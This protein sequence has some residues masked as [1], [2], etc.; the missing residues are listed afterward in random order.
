M[1]NL[2]KLFT[3]ATCGLLLSATLA[4]GAQL[5]I[6]IGPPRAVYERISVSPSLTIGAATGR[7]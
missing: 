7:L 2:N 6:R 4:A 1:M 3:T 5:S